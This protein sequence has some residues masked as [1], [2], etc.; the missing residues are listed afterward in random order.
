MVEGHPELGG[1]L[2]FRRRTSKALLER[3][4]RAIDSALC[5]PHRS[6]RPVV[7]AQLVE[8]RATHAL[9][10]KSLELG[11]LVILEAL[12]G[13]HQTDHSGL[14]DVVDLDA[15]RKLCGELAGEPRDE[16]GELLDSRGTVVGG[17]SGSGLHGGAPV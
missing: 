11:A 15:G 3:A 16:R 7:P 6:G 13:I 2:A 10:R 9:G 14:L 1:D 17:E 12:R 8:H 4:D 5:A